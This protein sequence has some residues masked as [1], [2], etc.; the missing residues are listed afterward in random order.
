MQ[1]IG[2]MYFSADSEEFTVAKRLSGIMTGDNLEFIENRLINGGTKRYA[3]ELRRLDGVEFEYKQMDYDGIAS[4]VKSYEA[5][6]GAYPEVVF[7]DNL[8]DFVD[9][10]DDW[11]GM[12]MLIRDLDAMSRETKSHV[13]V[14]HHAKIAP[15]DPKKQDAGRPPA[16]WE[17]Q[18]KI[19][20][21]PRLVLTVTAKESS[22]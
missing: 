18:G 14:L 17:I 19:T 6:Y 2:C 13:C 12:L 3:D 20:Q 22:A 4:C 7:I 15:S 5:V 10:P 11:G 16:D 9:S 21:I 1:G 8:I